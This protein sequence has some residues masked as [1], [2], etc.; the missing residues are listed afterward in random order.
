LPFLPLPG[1]L[2]APQ[3]S[4]DTADCRLARPPEEGLVSG[5]RRRDFA[6]VSMRRRSATRRLGPCRDQT[7]TGKPRPASLGTHFRPHS[8]KCFTAGCSSLT[9]P[10]VAP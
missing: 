3:T 8:G 10:T 2:T 4:R 9:D 7:F 5:L 6:L 1:C